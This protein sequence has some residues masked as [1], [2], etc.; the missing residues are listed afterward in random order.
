MMRRK[1]PGPFRSTVN[2]RAQRRAAVGSEAM[3]LV[4]FEAYCETLA[5][6][7]AEETQIPTS[8]MFAGGVKLG[9]LM[10]AR[11]PWL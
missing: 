2:L 7:A 5:F 6:L 11:E 3:R 8:F 10:R 9:Y 1:T 4:I